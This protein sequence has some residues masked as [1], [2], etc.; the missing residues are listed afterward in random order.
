MIIGSTF[1]LIVILYGF[2]YLTRILTKE[3]DIIDSFAKD[4]LSG[5]ELVRNSYEKYFSNTTEDNLSSIKN[6]QRVAIE[7]MDF[8]SINNKKAEK[9]FKNGLYFIFGLFFLVLSIL[10]IQKVFFFLK[11]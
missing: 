5:L 8:Q 10:D 6:S 2:Y 3:G 4:F 9:K 7:K 11:L 1:F